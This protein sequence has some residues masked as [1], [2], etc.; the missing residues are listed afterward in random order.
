[1]FTV[2]VVNKVNDTHLIP[3]EVELGPQRQYYQH[4]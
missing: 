2:R 1:M 3:T 4:K